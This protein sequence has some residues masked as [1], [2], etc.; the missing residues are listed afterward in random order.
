MFG[1]L[2]TLLVFWI[3]LNSLPLYG[4]SPTP[5]VT[6]DKP[7][8]QNANPKKQSKT[9]ENVA[10]QK[11]VVVTVSPSQTSEPPTAPPTKQEK[12]ESTDWD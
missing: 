1:L 6:T 3:L 2:K 4:E 11:P 9:D 8:Q 12:Q 5:G 10:E 7:N